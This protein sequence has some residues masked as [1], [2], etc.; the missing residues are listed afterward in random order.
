[1][2]FQFGLDR[3]WFNIPGVQRSLLLLLLLV[4]CATPAYDL[5]LLRA[6]RAKLGPVPEIPRL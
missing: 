3:G 4:R 5:S 6:G 2:P 1:M